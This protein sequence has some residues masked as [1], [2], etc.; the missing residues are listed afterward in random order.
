MC[1][2]PPEFTHQRV[3][4]E[5]VARAAALGDLGADSEAIPWPALRRVDIPDVEAY[6]FG[7]P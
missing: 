6:N 5:N 1:P 7:Q 2:D 4:R 3:R